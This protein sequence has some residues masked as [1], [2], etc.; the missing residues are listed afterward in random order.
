WRPADDDPGRAV[1]QV[2]ARLVGVAV[3][4]LNQLPEKSFLAFLNLLGLELLPPQAARAPLTFQLAEGSPDDAVVPARTQ[5]GAVLAAG[6]VDDVAF[7][8]ERDLV[9]SRSQLVAL[10]TREP[11]RDR[12][13]AQPLNGGFDV[14][15]GDTPIQHALYVSDGVLTMNLP[16]EI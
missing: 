16:R 12:Y 6:E 11:A 10:Y 8:T 4:R 2:F 7:E 1:V 15:R 13:A 5:V 14:F 9:V 3:D